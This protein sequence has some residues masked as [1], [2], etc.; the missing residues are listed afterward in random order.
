MAFSNNNYFSK[1][2]I[3]TYWPKFSHFFIKTFRLKADNE[4]LNQ[5][6]SPINRK[7][8][9]YIISFTSHRAMQTTIHLSDSCIGAVNITWKVIPN[10][11]S[12]RQGTNT[13]CRDYHFTPVK[14]LR[15][16]P[17]SC[18]SLTLAVTSV[19]CSVNR[20]KNPIRFRTARIHFT[21]T[22]CG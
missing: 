10:C 7:S 6:P 12:E 22:L 8:Q 18:F 17:E 1:R 21:F 4:P 2:G 9:K 14:N 20:P 15:S 19:I 13:K 3:L 5:I 11:H 16:P